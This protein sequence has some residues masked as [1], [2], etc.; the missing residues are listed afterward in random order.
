MS[1]LQNYYKN[2]V[3]PALKEKF[4]YKSIMQVPRL[5]KIVLNMTAGKEVTNSK[6]IEEVIN[7][8]TVISS[9][10][11]FQTRAKKSN[12][13]WKL[14]EGMPMGGKVTLRRERMWDFL[15]KLINVAMPRIRDFKGAN[16]RAFDSRGNYSLG[17]KEEIIFP[18]IEFDKIRRIKG[19]D[20]QLIT[21]AKSDKEAKALLELIGVPFAKGDK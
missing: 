14:R 20:V 1:N 19:L 12:A 15:D 2:N 18:E 13:S 3:V 10:K 17:I 11:P 21:S 6:A 5:E 9:Q 8:L 16:P 7:E 4:Q